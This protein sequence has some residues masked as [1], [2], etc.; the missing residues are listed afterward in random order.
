MYH[1][2]QIGADARF[3]RIA[4]AQAFQDVALLAFY[5]SADMQVGRSYIALAKNSRSF[6]IK[7]E[8]IK[9]WYQQNLEF[10]AT[11]WPEEAR[12]YIESYISKLCSN[13]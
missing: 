11:F 10:V 8:F 2:Y 3:H 5:L 1:I 4:G 6:R 7:P 9:D 12:K 13:E